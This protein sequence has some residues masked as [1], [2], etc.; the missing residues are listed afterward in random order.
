[1]WRLE[2][3][4]SKSYLL[5]YMSDYSIPDRQYQTYSLREIEQ[6]LRDSNIKVGELAQIAL[7]SIL[8]SSRFPGSLLKELCKKRESYHQFKLSYPLLVRIRRGERVP[9]YYAGYLK[10]HDCY[11]ALCNVWTERSRELLESWIK[12]NKKYVDEKRITFAPLRTNEKVY[13]TNRPTTKSNSATVSTPSQQNNL[14]TETIHPK[15]DSFNWMIEAKASARQK[16][17]VKVHIEF[18]ALAVLSE[19]QRSIFI[20]VL[21]IDGPCYFKV[22][23]KRL[24]VMAKNNPAVFFTPHRDVCEFKL[25]TVHG[26]LYNVVDNQRVVV[27]KCS[28][29]EL[30]RGFKLSRY[31][32]D[33][34]LHWVKRSSGQE[35]TNSNSWHQLSSNQRRLQNND[36]SVNVKSVRCNKNDLDICGR[37]PQGESTLTTIII[38]KESLQNAAQN[39]GLCII[40][41][42]YNRPETPEKY[43]QISADT[44][45]AATNKYPNS[46][47]SKCENGLWDFLL[48]VKDGQIYSFHGNPR[49]PVGLAT[50]I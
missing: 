36:K 38:N 26:V 33:L 6:S 13:N 21:G 23:A 2:V 14:V 29:F 39:G 48:D 35:K 44:L 10:C 15:P 47:I 43:F 18:M 41:L 46:F 19:L 32:Q 27:G 22:K 12:C 45:L 7:C 17:E 8:Q 3:Y 20:R 30:V 31:P 24:Y 16:S 28:S 50:L 37:M 40:R 5:P 49:I 4:T 34:P 1:M 42:T 9:H 25:D 11:Y